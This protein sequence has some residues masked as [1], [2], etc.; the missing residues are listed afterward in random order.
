VAEVQQQLHLITTKGAHT[1]TEKLDVYSRVRVVK[2]AKLE[3]T[4]PEPEAIWRIPESVMTAS[5][6]MR[7]VASRIYEARKIPIS[8]SQAGW[9]AFTVVFSALTL[10]IIA[11]LSF[12]PDRIASLVPDDAFYYIVL[13]KNQASLGRWTFDGVAPATGFHLLWGYML[14]ATYYIWPNIPFNSLFILSSAIGTLCVSVS[15]A[16]LT[17]T[18]ARRFGYGAIFGVLI[19]FFNPV[20]LLQST[21]IM[22]SPLVILCAATLWFLVFRPEIKLSYA[23]LASVACVGFLGMLARSDFGLVPLVLFCVT[24]FGV[25]TKRMASTAA[26]VATA[27]LIGSVLGLG[28]VLAHNYVSAGHLFQASALI[29]RHWSIVAGDSA[30]PGLKLVLQILVV[31]K[32]WGMFSWFL[33]FAPIGA[34]LLARASEYKRFINASFEEWAII[35]AAILVVVGYIALYSLNSAALQNWYCATLLGAI[36]LF[37]GILLAPIGQ[38]QFGK[39]AVLTII[40]AGLG[41]YSSLRPAWAWQQS[42]RDAGL[43]LRSS[44]QINPVASWNAG[45]ISYFAERPVINIDGLVNDDILEFVK[46]GNLADYILARKIDYIVDFPEMLSELEAGR[47]GY[48][49]GKLAS[50]LSVQQKLAPDLPVN[51]W[52]GSVISLFKVD[53]NCLTNRR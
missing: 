18:A 46:S 5:Q 34:L 29:K 31:Y 13:S 45:Y 30:I 4:C 51:E 10:R 35:G 1:M 42:M 28:F 15:A 2:D 8:S 3:E 33:A 22:E 47:G 50:C 44:P 26:A 39:M 19:A 12:G 36:S 11:L 20:V 7:S 48:A 6:T 41:L 53:R 9:I 40:L 17:V 21:E 37:V 14:A 27:G 25:L 32:V 43:F 49:N 38:D 52:M 16:L 23:S 24:V